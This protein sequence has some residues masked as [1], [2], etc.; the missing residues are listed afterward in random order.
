MVVVALAGMA[1]AT[2][3]QL[4]R[5]RETAN[6]AMTS[7]GTKAICKRVGAP[8]VP[9][10][11]RP[12]P[13]ERTALKGCRSERL[14]YGIGVKADY[15]KARK[16]AV[17]EAEHGDDLM[18]G[19][20][21]VL[22]QIYA[23]GLGV[24]RNPDVATAFAC[25]VDAAPMEIDLR[26]QA[27]QEL[28]RKPSRFDICD[29][30]TSGLLGGFC[31]GREADLAAVGRDARVKALVASLPPAAR[32]AW[33]ALQKAFDAYVSASARGETDLSGTLRGAFITEAEEALRNQQLKDL[34]RLRDHQWPA[35]GAADARDADAKLNARYRQALQRAAGSDNLTTIEPDDIRTAQRA[36]LVY[37][38][39]YLRFAAAAAPTVSRDA[40][41]TRLTRLRLADLEGLESN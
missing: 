9:L 30:A 31:A 11:D 1:G 14:Y 13:L 40:V 35:A 33:P 23:N 20:S 3:A 32:S 41:L 4:P 37:R 26:I 12:T 10:A 27:L 28:K 8:H 34:E 16:C 5:A 19:G 15:A 38:D 24:P 6:F 25:T 21:T 22:M 18:F 39:A 29:L 17:I 2:L 36:W 7:D